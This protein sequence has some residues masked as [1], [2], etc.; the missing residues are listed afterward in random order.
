MLGSTT[1][2]LA[3]A[4]WVVIIL[5]I[6]LYA[7][8]GG[9][10]KRSFEDYVLADRGFSAR[11]VWCSVLGT[12]IGGGTLAALAGKMYDVGIVYIFVPLGVAISYGLLAL[13]SSRYRSSGEKQID[14][15]ERNQSV[16]LVDR[17]AREYGKSVRYPAGFLVVGIMASF[18]AIQIRAGGTAISAYLKIDPFIASALFFSLIAV[19]VYLAGARADALTDMFQVIVILIGICAGLTG[20]I[21]SGKAM[22][23]FNT[24]RALSPDVFSFPK[25]SLGLVIGFMILPFFSLHADA[26][27]H[28]KILSARDDTAAKRGLWGAS[29]TYL[30][31]GIMLLMLAMLARGATLQLNHPDE[32]LMSFSLAVFPSGLQILIILA[33]LSAIASTLDSQAILFSSIVVNDLIPALPHRNRDTRTESRQKQNFVAAR[34]WAFAGLTTGLSLTL[35]PL[36][37]FDF[38]TVIWV[39]AMTAFGIPVVGL[40]WQWLRKGLTE[41]FVKW[42]IVLSAFTMIFLALVFYRSGVAELTAVMIQCTFAAILLYLGIAVIAALVA[43]RRAH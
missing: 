17:L 14:Y 40:L 7:R 12:Y 21:V 32:V 34:I 11:L 2:L 9:A 20:L 38:L 3:T 30:F 41:A 39:T 22:D 10:R 26:G 25:G 31:F 29:V 4:M 43:Q 16:S 27:I 19:Y 1:L 15:L 6:S 13:F 35:I 33:F 24:A 36:K 18:M 37:L 28:Q 23:L 8:Y 5:A 42:G